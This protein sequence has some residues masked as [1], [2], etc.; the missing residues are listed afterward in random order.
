VDFIWVFRTARELNG[1]CAGDSVEWRAARLV[2]IRL[3][4]EL[5]VLRSPG[6]NVK[7]TLRT[8]GI[9]RFIQVDWLAKYEFP[10]KFL[11]EKPKSG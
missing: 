7:N 11:S 5:V 2:G 4:A 9:S 1:G 8:I 6:A 3:G 10:D